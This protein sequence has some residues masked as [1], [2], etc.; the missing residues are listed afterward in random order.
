MF[1]EHL[2]YRLELFLSLFVDLVQLGLECF[3]LLINL[4]Q[5]LCFLVFDFL[6]YF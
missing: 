4:F 2:Y 3:E 1:G 6:I 5:N